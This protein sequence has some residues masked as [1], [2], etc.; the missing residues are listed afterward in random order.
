MWV[1][2]D[3]LADISRLK[4]KHVHALGLLKMKY[5]IQ[6]GLHEVLYCCTMHTIKA[7]GGRVKSQ[8]TWHQIAF[9]WPKDKIRLKFLKLKIGQN[10]NQA[11]IDYSINKE[12]F[13]DLNQTGT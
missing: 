8:V 13:K 1:G 11:M 9:G 7:Q 10:H 2:M 5:D 3:T 4:I 12:G 6:K